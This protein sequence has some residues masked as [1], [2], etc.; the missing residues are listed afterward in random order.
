[1]VVTKNM[2]VH[3]QMINKNLI[4]YSLIQN[5]DIYLSSASLFFCKYRKT[6]FTRSYDLNYYTLI[7]CGTMYFTIKTYFPIPVS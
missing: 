1:M 6:G 3:V 4:W 2:L 5:L 7:R